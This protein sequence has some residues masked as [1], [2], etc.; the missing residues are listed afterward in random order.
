MLAPERLRPLLTITRRLADNDAPT[1]PTNLQGTI[2]G[3][4]GFFR[5]QAS[6]DN[7]GEAK[8]ELYL[9]D[10]TIPF[11][12]TGFGRTEITR[13]PIS[14]PPGT[15]RVTVRARDRAGNLSGP[16]NAVTVQV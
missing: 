2:T 15:H 7:S 5:W 12:M 14:L 1:A 4:H 8:Y 11:A 16:S 3:I 10:A 13:F 9:D 6:T